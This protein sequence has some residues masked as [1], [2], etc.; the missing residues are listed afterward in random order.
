MTTCKKS[1]S[2][3]PMP[4]VIDINQLESC[5]ATSEAT[6]QS[7]AVPSFQ[8]P[9]VK[10]QDR[11]SPPFRPGGRG[12]KM[13]TAVVEASH[14]ATEKSDSEQDF[15]LNNPF[16]EPSWVIFLGKPSYFAKIVSK[17]SLD[18]VLIQPLHPSVS[19]P[20]LLVPWEGH[21]LMAKSSTL[22]PVN[23]KREPGGWRVVENPKLRVLME[24]L[25]KNATPFLCPVSIATA[26]S[27]S[28]EDWD[29]V[30][31]ESSEFGE[32][33]S[34]DSSLFP[35]LSCSEQEVTSSVFGASG[36]SAASVVPSVTL[37]SGSDRGSASVSS[38]FAS[39]CSDSR[40][41]ACT[42]GVPKSPNRY[43]FKK[44]SQ[45]VLTE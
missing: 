14:K 30:S 32:S 17:P 29:L 37:V 13:L 24:H 31:L 40:S 6:K 22:H 5:I 9:K 44:N 21:L 3:Q 34:V 45:R 20:H 11:H 4:H 2:F 43:A 10:Y 33:S 16:V 19:D 39:S 15:N 36:S 8:V 27:Q 7:A 25:K 1:V 41:F 12:S 42:N 26:K 35:L 18:D 23:M 38:A 28:K